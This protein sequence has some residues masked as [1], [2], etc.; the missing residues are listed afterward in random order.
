LVSPSQGQRRLLI[1]KPIKEGVLIETHIPLEVQRGQP[2][3]EQQQE[4]E[5]QE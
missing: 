2:R 5:E 4:Q 1:P 3:Q